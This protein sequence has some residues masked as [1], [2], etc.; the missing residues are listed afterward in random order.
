LSKCYQLG[1]DTGWYAEREYDSNAVFTIINETI[2]I[3]EDAEYNKKIC[4]ALMD[5]VQTAERRKQENR[6]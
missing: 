1:K 2:N 6:L 3:Y 5:S 4:N